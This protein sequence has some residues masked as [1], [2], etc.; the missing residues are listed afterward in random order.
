VSEHEVILY[1][2]THSAKSAKIQREGLRPMQTSNWKK[3]GSGE[4]YGRG[5]VHAFEFPEDARRW[6]AKMEWDVY[7]ST[8]SGAGE[9]CN[10]PD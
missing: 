7:H 2:V 10:V 5:E 9:H 6:A 4:R 3:A 1:H 8:G